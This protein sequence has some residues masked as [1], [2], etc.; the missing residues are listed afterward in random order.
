M[1]LYCRTAVRIAAISLF[2]LPALA[3]A[4]DSSRT[5]T[6]MD[7]FQ[8]QTAVDP[9][10]SL[11]GKK[12]VYVRRFADPMTDKRYSNLWV[13]NADGT[14]HRPISS[15]NHAY[16]S[17]R[18]SPDGTRIAFLSDID[19]KPQIYVRWMDTGQTARITNL[20]QSP[21]AIAWSP[22]GRMI[23]FSSLVAGK[24]PHLAD[25]PAAPSGAKWADPPTAYDR[26]VYRFNGTGYLKPGYIQVFIVSAEGGA[27]RQVTNG[28][29]AN[30]GNEFGPT[31]AAWSPDGKFLL[32]AA[33]RH[34]ES[35]HEYLDTE[36]YEFNVADGA[37]RALTNR[38]GPDANPDV[39]PNGKWIAYTG[40][41][42][43]YQGHQTTKLYIMN[44]D[45]TG[46]RS[47][48]DKLDR[49]I[50]SPH[51]ASDNT[52]VYSSTMTKVTPRSGSL[53][54]TAASRKLPTTP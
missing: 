44:R 19:G 26:L 25:L 45:G 32:V 10:I 50:L 1:T 7:E 3:A 20:E 42:D 18:W 5:L 47:V 48:T 13:I 4:Q 52:G 39:S 38:K 53:R 30:G 49:D 36:I 51:W 23:S 43:R 9:Q 35:E 54:R 17:P 16:T 28:N 21:D 12:I 46:A 27:P 34:A 33:N 41:D 24:G 31:R 37:L 11:D 29:F 22:D 8:L 14:D 40:F 15:G 6:V 2:W